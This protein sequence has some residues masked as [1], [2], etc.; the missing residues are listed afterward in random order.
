MAGITRKKGET[1]ESFFRR[2]SKKVQES[3]RLLQAK[4]IRFF[5][6][7]KSRTKIK[8]DALRRI[9]IRDEKEYLKK[10]GKSEEPEERRRY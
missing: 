2:F 1:F 8:A 3:G 5:D 4:K 7:H 10:I 6:H 9:E